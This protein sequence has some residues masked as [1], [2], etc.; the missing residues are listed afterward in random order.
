MFRKRLM[1]TLTFA[2]KLNLNCSR[3]LTSSKMLKSISDNL[4]G[5]SLNRKSSDEKSS[6]EVNKN[7]SVVKL[8]SCAR[9]YELVRIC[10][11]D[12]TD[13]HGNLKKS[14]SVVERIFLLELFF[15]GL[16]Q[17]GDTKFLCFGGFM[18]KWFFLN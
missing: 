7:K 8:N 10:V 3:F 14:L 17:E 18:L 4:K 16:D 5:L 9:S 6:D 13:L 2:I 1:N 12:L 15:F 11:V